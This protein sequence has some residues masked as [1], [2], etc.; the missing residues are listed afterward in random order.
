[1]WGCLACAQ[2]WLISGQGSWG[3]LFSGAALVAWLVALDA[4]RK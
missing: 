4:G 3:F 1:M 2:P